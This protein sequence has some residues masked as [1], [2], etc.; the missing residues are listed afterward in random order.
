[1]ARNRQCGSVEAKVAEE[2]REAHRRR[3]HGDGPGAE[4]PEVRGIGRR[5]KYTR[6]NYEP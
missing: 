2:S 4:S 5:L 6:L 3:M 1:M